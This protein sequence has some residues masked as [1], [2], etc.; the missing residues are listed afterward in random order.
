MRRRQVSNQRLAL[1]LCTGYEGRSSNWRMRLKEKEVVD[2]EKG[3]VCGFQVD[4]F[5]LS[6]LYDALQPVRW[7]I[8]YENHPDL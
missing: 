3:V 5:S 8:N 7:N 1:Q 2:L 4:S 6:N